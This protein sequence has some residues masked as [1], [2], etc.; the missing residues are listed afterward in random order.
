MDKE[1]IKV[2][3]HVTTQRKY[4]KDLRKNKKGIMT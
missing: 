3:H 2:F 4:L 1:K